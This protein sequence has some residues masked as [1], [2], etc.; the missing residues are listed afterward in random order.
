[1]WASI[2]WEQRT[3]FH[4]LKWV[5]AASPPPTHLVSRVCSVLQSDTLPAPWSL[6]QQ[7]WDTVGQFVFLGRAG[8]FT[9]P[10]LCT[11]QCAG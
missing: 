1:M 8:G 2:L 9:C 3:A 5:R 6:C 11:V 4:A 7:L 10:S